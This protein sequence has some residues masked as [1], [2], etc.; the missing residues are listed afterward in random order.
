VARNRR[1]RPRHRAVSTETAAS[2]A[3]AP[4]G[5]GP[6][7]RRTVDA[8]LRRAMLRFIGI[9]LLSAV[10]LFL[11]YWISDTTGRFDA[12]NRLNAQLSGVILDAIGID[13]TLHGTVVQFRTGGMEVIS[14]CSGVYVA[15]LFAAGVLAFP[16]NWRARLKGLGLGLLAIFAINVLR[17]VTLGAIIAHKRAWLPLFHEYLWQVLFILVVAGLYLMW[18]ERMVPR[19]RLDP[20]T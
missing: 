17:L 11:I 8:A 13:N 7:R 20:A 10:V 14:E 18:I 9:F 3:Q 15:I 16:A 2:V 4:D 12:V 5:P 19:E 1:R 6:G